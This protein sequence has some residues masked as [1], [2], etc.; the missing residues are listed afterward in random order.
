MRPTQFSTPVQFYAPPHLVAAMRA[1]A[2]REGR[3]ISELIRAA[4]R[5]DLLD[6]A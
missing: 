3:T 1:K 5:R 2:G 4:V 6:A